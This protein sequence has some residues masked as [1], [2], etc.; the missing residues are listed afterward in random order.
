MNL[1]RQELL[2]I[3]VICGLVVEIV[4]MNLQMKQE[5]ILYNRGLEHCIL[6]PSQRPINVAFL[7]DI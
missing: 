7:Y 6:N 1:L 3:R 2:Q 5:E 4:T